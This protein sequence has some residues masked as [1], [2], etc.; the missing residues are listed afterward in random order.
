VAQARRVRGIGGTLAALGRGAGAACRWRIAGTFWRLARRETSRWY[1]NYR[2]NAREVAHL[3]ERHW[4]AHAP[5]FTV[6]IPVFNT[7]ER[8]LREAVASVLGQIYERWELVCVDDGSSN[9]EVAAVLDEFSRRD[10]RIV[11]LHNERN[12]GVS[13][14][15]NAGLRRASGDYVCFMDHDDYLEPH[16]LWRVADAILAT[17]ADFV[18]CDEVVTAERD[19]NVVLQVQARPAFS[20]DYYL[21]HPYLV[22]LVAVERALAEKI[23]GVDETLDISQDVDFN[24]RAFEVARKVAHVPD[25]LYRWRKHAGSTG[26]RRAHRVP[27]ATCGAL[28]RHLAR[29]GFEA[30]VRPGAQF[31]TFRIRFFPVTRERVAVI[32]PTK[33]RRDLLEKCI[34]SIRATTVAGSFDLVVVDHESDDP[35]T[36]AY[37]ADVARQGTVLR[38]AGEFNFSRLNNFAAAQIGGRYDYYLFMNNDIEAVEAGWFEAMLDLA[39]RADVGVVGA[40]LLF[41]DR[42]VQHAGVIIGIHG[43]AEHAFK[44]ARFFSGNERAVGRDCSLVATR[45]YSAVTAACMMMRSRVFD[46]VGGFDEN[47]AVGFNDTDLCLRVIRRGYKVLN[48][49]HAVLVHHESATRGRSAADQ[50][51]RD[52]ALFTS[53][54]R[55]L[56]RTGDPYYSP[57]LSTA[58]PRFRLRENARSAEYV[59]AR[60]VSDFRP[61]KP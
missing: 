41:P 44:F 57:L 50:H 31:N 14:A 59:A 30:D 27:D 25:I 24:L 56:I 5:R 16:A 42:T 1:E 53:R 39:K 3:S 36:R 52:T 4:P 10:P 61:R 43:R 21:C 29:L 33:N 46:E 54:Y 2:L 58:D 28:R 18:C 19:L 11:H 35:E 60:T 8:W 47:L 23:G 48:H 13:A 6:V 22:H 32:I 49:A 17:G 45:D 9:P 37:L 34:T 12:R 20:H 15:T 40:T 38:Y 7:P 26:H 51:P 55:E